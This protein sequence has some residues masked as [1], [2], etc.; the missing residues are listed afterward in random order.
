MDKP[1][2][3]V[4]TPIYDWNECMKYLREKYGV[5]ERD[6][7]GKFKRNAVGALRTN[8]RPYLDFWHWVV[9][10]KS[11]VRGGE[12][13]VG[14]EDVRELATREVKEDEKLPA[15]LKGWRGRILGLLLEEF[16]ENGEQ[17]FLTDW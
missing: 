5:D 4:R 1:V 8:N 12:V 14:P 9:D 15:D 6:Y 2:K 3:K 16:G 11:P 13:W 10:Q 7:A 17:T